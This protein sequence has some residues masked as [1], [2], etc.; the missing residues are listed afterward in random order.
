MTTDTA[1]ALLAEAICPHCAN[2]G[3]V[4]GAP[5]AVCCNRPTVSREC[6]GSPVPQQTQEQCQWCADRA[7]MLD[8]GGW[9][10]VKDGLPT[11]PKAHEHSYSEVEVVFNRNGEREVK[12][13]YYIPSM[14]EWRLT[15]S[16]SSW[17]DCITHWQP[18]PP[19][20]KGDIK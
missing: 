2:T 11:Q 16:P 7:A 3:C 14:N 18:L 19:L 8:S 10:S 13:G 5:V 12:R 20:P 6:C 17:N 4:E 15:G 9:I 1:L